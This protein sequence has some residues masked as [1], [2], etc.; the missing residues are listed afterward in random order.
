[1]ALFYDAFKNQTETYYTQLYKQDFVSLE[2][3]WKQFS[4]PNL[5]P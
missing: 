1:M 3:H 2:I 5:L 4:F